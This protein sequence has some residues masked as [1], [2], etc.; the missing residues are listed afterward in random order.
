MGNI[1]RAD[2][3]Y[4]G[5]FPADLPPENGGT[6]I[7]M[8]L[9]W[10]I[11][12]GLASPRL[13]KEAG[14]SLQLLRERRITGRRLLFTE[15]DEKF[16]DALLTQTGTDFTRD[17]YETD[18]YF[19]DY[20][21][22]LAGGLPSTYHVEDSW[23]NYDKIAAVIDERF[24]QWQ[25]G[26]KPL[27]SSQPQ[28][29]TPADGSGLTREDILR[30]AAEVWEGKRPESDLQKYGIRIAEKDEGEEARERL[31]AELAS[32]GLDLDDDDDDHAA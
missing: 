4:G 9:A 15:L 28:A 16:F 13:V 24:S 31:L 25:R 21:A 18:V 6:H 17:Y 7:G 2:W 29:Q 3:H 22:I 19:A 10:V 23:E 30:I 12:R 5:N 8:Y 27:Q 14:R 26:V 32:L 1:D 20:D 11:D